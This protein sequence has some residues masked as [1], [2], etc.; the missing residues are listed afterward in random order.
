MLPWELRGYA[1]QIN[2]MAQTH[3]TVTVSYAGRVIYQTK[4]A[5]G[6]FI[7]TDLNQSVQEHWMSR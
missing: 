2:G 7:I 5:P 4:V 1:P 6:P 3:A